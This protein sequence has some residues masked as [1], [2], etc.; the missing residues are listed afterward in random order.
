MRLGWALQANPSKLTRKHFPEWLEHASKNIASAYFFNPRKQHKL[1]Y[2]DSAIMACNLD[3]VAATKN[4]GFHSLIQHSTTLKTYAIRVDVLCE[5]STSRPSYLLIYRVE[6]RSQHFRFVKQNA[7][8]PQIWWRQLRFKGSR[9]L[10]VM[11]VATLMAKMLAGWPQVWLS[12]CTYEEVVL[13]ALPG[14]RFGLAF[15]LRLVET[16]TVHSQAAFEMVL[17]LF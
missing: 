14:Q 15:K 1:V 13:Y 2:W 6:L 11:V 4:L 12:K 16:R 17:I 8:V 5:A 9:C 10:L 7:I 3:M